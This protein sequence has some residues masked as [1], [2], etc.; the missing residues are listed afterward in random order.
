MKLQ[1]QLNPNWRRELA[2]ADRRLWL[3]RAVA[4]RIEIRADPIWAVEIFWKRLLLASGTLAVGSYLLVATAAYF[5]WA[6]LPQ[7]QVR[8]PDV[9]LAPVRWEQ[10]RE[11]RGD[12]AIATGLAQLKERNYIEALY[13]LRAGVS[14]S[15][16]NAP[17][18]IALA[19]LLA[20]SD[21]VQSL[22]LLEDGL[23]LTPDNLDLLRL[24][25]G[26]Y[27][28][29]QAHGRALQQTEQMLV[30]GRHPALSPAARFLVGIA[31]VELLLERGDFAAADHTLEQIEPLAVEPAGRQTWHRLKVAYYLKRQEINEAETWY[32]RHLRADA[33]D[34][35]VLRLP[36]E[37]AL[38][39]HD[40][41]A[42]ARAIR[43]LKAAAPEQPGVYLL[44]YRGWL[45]AHRP[46]KAE[47]AERE[48]YTVFGGSDAA[49]QAF[50]AQAV[51]LSQ[52]E[53]L[54][55]CQQVAVA[56]RLSPFAFQVHATE[57]ALRQG[58][59]EAAL[60]QLRLWEGTI[61]T[62]KPA[63]RFYP[64]YLSRLVRSCV[65]GGEKQSTLLLSLL[66]NS[67][68]NAQV[69]AYLLA[70]ESLER[71]GDV[72]AAR[73]AVEAGLKLYPAS[74]PLLAVQSRLQLRLAR[75]GVAEEYLHPGPAAEPPP[76]TA[77]EALARLDAA[78]H[79][80]AF[81]RARRLLQD[82]QS[83]QPA[84][85]TTHE[86]DF[87]LRKVTLALLTE[88]KVSVRPVLM[89]YL[90][91][92][93]T[94]AEVLRLVALARELIGQ[95]RMTEARCVRDVVAG[96]P[97]I[98]PAVR[99]AL[100][101]LN[102][103]DDFAAQAANAPAALAALDQSLAAHQYAQ[104]EALLDY[105]KANQLDWMAA[106]RTDL[107]VREVQV[108]L[109]LD[110]RPLAY[111]VWKEIGIRAGASRSAAFKLVRDLRARG[112]VENAQLLAKELVRL[113]PEDPAVAKLLK[114]TAAAPTP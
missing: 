48:Y 36:A 85:L 30:A 68:G 98:T 42:L 103:P 61:D 22:K 76:A 39:R 15:P 11:R 79:D 91:H 29:Q 71:C 46:S 80:E 107:A 14:R 47:E 21:P 19:R 58:N 8:W 28:V 110:Q 62:L 100:G 6:R 87:D 77:A 56:N 67:R 97:G 78:L 32:E 1:I 27:A 88:D 33:K 23:V 34:P 105:L 35:D 109:G 102:L 25:L 106:A 112:E 16:R 18:R 92:H 82:L 50:A 72:D 96:Q 12:T 60:R 3:L 108:R 41:E 94:T 65:S 99:E 9:V 53:A 49:L 69:G 74:D 113:L 31:R 51:A 5:W 84:W 4:L 10:L 45:N 81:L 2:P 63:Q 93:H 13:S 73:Q 37:I 24:A 55:R 59:A 52:P 83:R 43:R 104:A 54:A 66:A 7:N 26:T 38:A 64:T 114:E 111:A 90:E 95:N 75:S 40:D 44:A 101:A 86:V 89:T 17:G 70:A 20:L 57:L